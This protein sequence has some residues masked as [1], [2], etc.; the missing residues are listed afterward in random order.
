LLCRVL[1]NKPCSQNAARLRAHDAGH[2]FSCT[3]HTD[4]RPPAW[5]LHGC[6]PSLPG[7]VCMMGS[8]YNGQFEP[9][10]RE[11]AVLEDIFQVC[12]K[13]WRPVACPL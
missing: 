11:D 8:T 2:L 7:V 4:L 3:L 10:E 6:L 9:V 13:S 12:K 1:L 5:P